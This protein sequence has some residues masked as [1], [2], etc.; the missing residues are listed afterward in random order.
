[1]KHCDSK[2]QAAGTGKEIERSCWIVDEN[3]TQIMNRFQPK[4][5]WEEKDREKED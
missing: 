4:Q 1:M 5:S 3:I 2:Q